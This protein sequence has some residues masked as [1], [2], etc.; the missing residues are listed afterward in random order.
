MVFLSDGD[1][2][3]KKVLI[4]GADG[5]TGRHLSS[6]LSDKGFTVISLG[7]EHAENPSM[8][9]CDLTNKNSTMEIIGEIRPD[10]VIHLAAV[11]FVGERDIKS[12]Y[13]VNLFGTINLLEALACCQPS[14]QKIVIASSANV[15]GNPGVEVIDESICPAPVNHYAN[16]KLAMEHMVRTWFDRFPII[17][18]RPFNYTGPGQSERFLIPKIVGHFKRKEKKISLGNLEISRDFSDVQDIVE[19]YKKLLISEAKSIIVNIC[20]GNAVSLFEVIKIMNKISGYEIM[21]ET[22]PELVRSNEIKSMKGSN[23]LLKRL[24]NFVPETSFEVI[25]Q[26]IYQY[27]M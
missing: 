13:N 9:P 15:Y 4:T 19:S 26:R 7:G 6:A 16:S 3:Q 11:S 27:L 12:F 8:I 24:I 23:Q 5:F 14:P 22:D 21:L 20:S 18:A 10:Y 25:L 1:Y 2:K 17:I